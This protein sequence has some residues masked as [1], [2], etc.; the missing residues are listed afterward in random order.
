MHALE[1]A[2]GNQ[3][4]TAPRGIV[5]AL[6]GPDGVGKSSQTAQLTKTL[7]R[8]FRCTAVYLGSGDGGWRLRQLAQRQLGKWRKRRAQPGPSGTTVTPR[9]E[10]YTNR[11][12]STALGGL[13]VALERLMTL[14]R[15]MRIAKAGSIVISDRWPQNLQPGM[16]DG[17]LRLDERASPMVRLLSRLERTLYRQMEKR[18]PGLTVHLVSDFETSNARKPGDRSRS[19]FDRRLALMQE[20]RALNPSIK[21]VD[22]RNEFDAV[23]G[24]LAKCVLVALSMQTD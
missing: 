20:M 18:G 2:V 10:F 24:E 12:L 15:A 1:T 14:R 9:R 13:V 11:S 22:A 23:T 5:V 21:V 17:P 19:Q 7:G 6:V 3:C 8:E 16:F 4:L